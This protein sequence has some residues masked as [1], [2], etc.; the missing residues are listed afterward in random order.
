MIA[1][2][3]S[4]AVAAIVVDVVFENYRFSVAQPDDG[5]RRAAALIGYSLDPPPDPALIGEPFFRLRETGGS[6]YN[7]RPERQFA[8]WSGR[9]LWYGPRLL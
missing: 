4:V 7:T 6:T 5:Y 9:G 3:I 8:L 1:A 2:S